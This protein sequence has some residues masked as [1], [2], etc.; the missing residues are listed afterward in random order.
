MGTVELRQGVRTGAEGGSRGGSKGSKTGCE[1]FEFC[2]R[3]IPRAGARA[4]SLGQ[5]P[6]FAFTPV[7]SPS[8]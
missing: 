1:G 8:L 7:K 5:V 3:A 6:S 4:A 2:R